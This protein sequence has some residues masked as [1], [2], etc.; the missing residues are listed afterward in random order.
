MSDGLQLLMR[1]VSRI[2]EAVTAPL[3]LPA[4]LMPGRKRLAAWLGLLAIIG[5]LTLTSWHNSLPANHHAQQA[6]HAQEAGDHHHDDDGNAPVDNA[7]HVAAHVVLQG[8]AL[9]GE[10]LLATVLLLVAIVFS[11]G[12]LVGRRSLPPL[13]ILRPPRS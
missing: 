11:S 8:V 7:E 12:P 10:M 2:C 3:A 6:A 13:T 9:P 4:K 5:M 1:P